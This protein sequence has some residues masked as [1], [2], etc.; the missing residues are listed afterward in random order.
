M[1]RRD[2]KFVYPIHQ[3][4]RY[5]RT[6]CPTW[7]SMY[8]WHFYSGQLDAAFNSDDRNGILIL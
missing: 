3:F 6:F 4:Q 2:A 5:N 8:P 7:L 1:Q